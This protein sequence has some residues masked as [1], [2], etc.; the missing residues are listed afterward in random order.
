MPPSLRRCIPL[1][2]LAGLCAT[3]LAAC[4][5]TLQDQPVA[6][7]TL[8]RLVMVRRNPVY[9]L[10]GSFQGL[11]I[12]EVSADPGGA[13]TIQ[14]GDCTEGGQSTC[15][16]PL[17]VV[18]SPDNSFKPGGEG[19][20]RPISL[21][22]ARAVSSAAGRTIVLATGGVIVAVYAQRPQLARA[23]ADTMVPIN[24]A[25]SPGEPLP[26]A[27]ADTGYAAKA[28]PSQ[29]PPLVRIPRPLRGGSVAR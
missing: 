11:R 25:A 20:N 28:L 18:T 21:R 14:Y 7:S 27:L 15:V 23:A 3:T 6:A 4:G 2:A 16:Y 29:E 5:D 24:R 26:P 12:A 13:F 17:S 19:L 1:V 9:W 22:A 10:G 8:E